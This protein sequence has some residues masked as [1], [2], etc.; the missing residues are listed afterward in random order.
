MDGL[1]VLMTLAPAAAFCTLGA[2]WLL[3]GAPGERTVARVTAAV[4]IVVCV[5]GAA[6][7]V[8]LW[9]AGQPAV[10]TAALPWL[11]VGDYEVQLALV[12][13]RLSWP[14]VMVNAVLVALV[15][16]FSVRYVHRDRGF[17]RF[18]LLLH[19][20]SAGALLTLTAASLEL[21]I[22]GWEFVGL[23]SVLL[24]A[25]FD[26]R[27]DPVRNAGRVFA[28]Y[29]VADVGLIAAVFLVHASAGTTRFGELFAGDWPQQQLM[30][31]GATGVAIAFLFVLAAAGK[32][33]QGPFSA[34]LPRAMEGPTPSSA[35]FYGAISVH[36]GAYLL[37][38][39]W[40]ILA[41][42]PIAAGSVV[43]TGAFTAVMATCVHR[44]ATDAK[45]SIAYAGMA[46]LGLIFVE[47]GLGYPRLALAHMV[48]HA[49]ARTLQFLRAPSM[50]HDYHRAHA[51]AGTPR[52][53][54]GD[55]YLRLLPTRV[56]RWLYRASLERAFMDG[57]IEWLVVA[58]LV[59]LARWFDA[60]ESVPPAA[61]ATETA[62][63][64]S[65]MYRTGR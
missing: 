10:K 42:S 41:G 7:G 4:S 28:F 60:L 19:L 49:V 27:S 36:L 51:A 52:K 32:S 13:D 40:P 6:L 65:R 1:L 14:L 59:R 18:F 21:V 47:I 9:S 22:V 29:R 23:T 11:V 58:R 35:I 33:A 53:A 3:R 44:A 45:T 34:W 16:V 39:V 30:A 55:G 62:Q 24:V 12:V 61:A 8:Q 46:Q 43:A 15:G 25:Y 56:R 38:R 31:P 54:A 57:L 37:L 2:T 50:L 48:G 17:F 63:P 5:A 64:E 20:F 26:D